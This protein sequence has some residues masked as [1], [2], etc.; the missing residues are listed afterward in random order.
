MKHGYQIGP[1][2]FTYSLL[3]ACFFKKLW[4]IFVRSGKWF[5]LIMEASNFICEL[6]H[7]NCRHLENASFSFIDRDKTVHDCSAWLHYI[8]QPVRSQPVNEDG[9]IPEAPKVPGVPKHVLRIFY[10]GTLHTN[11]Q[12]CQ[13]HC[14]SHVFPV[15]NANCKK[16]F[17]LFVSSFV[18]KSCLLLIIHVVCFNTA[19]T[20]SC[21]SCC[22]ETS[23]LLFN[24]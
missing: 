3:C 20:C 22:F 9:Q 23:V 15:K 17:K 6:F 11:S 13:F 8:L 5:P 18:C 10:V 14:E 19:L 24:G 1:V 4:V 12:F 2:S 21:F 16:N 7:H